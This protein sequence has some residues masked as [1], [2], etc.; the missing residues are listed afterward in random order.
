MLK[1]T[2]TEEEIAS[3]SKE[4]DIRTPFT[5]NISE[6]HVKV[7]QKVGGWSTFADA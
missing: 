7:G 2:L 5:A 4:G 6:I 1:A 3:L